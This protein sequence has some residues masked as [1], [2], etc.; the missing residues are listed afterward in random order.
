[1]C[2]RS[3]FSFH[4][5]FVW[6]GWFLTANKSFFHRLFWTL[7]H[8]LFSCAI[9]FLATFRIFFLNTRVSRFV[10]LCV[11]LWNRVLCF[12]LFCLLVGV[13][14]FICTR[15]KF[16]GR[17][18]V[19]KIFLLKIWISFTEG[20]CTW[21]WPYCAKELN[22]NSVPC[23][24]FFCLILSLH[25]PVACAS[26]GSQDQLFYR[27]HNLSPLKHTGDW[28]D[29]ILFPSLISQAIFAVVLCLSKNEKN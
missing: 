28:F 2:A 3:Q 16:R 24:F 19:I 15:R 22:V 26:N 7:K 12:V 9:A 25:S 8:H 20:A 29:L 6:G 13:F 21:R 23:F 5:V 18:C 17:I 10:G 27:S 14:V 11:C 4:S 1:M